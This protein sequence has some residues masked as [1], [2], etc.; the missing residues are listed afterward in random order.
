M[1]TVIENINSLFSVKSDIRQ[2][3]EDKGVDMS[4]TPFTS[5]A[6]KISEIPSGGGDLKGII[7]GTTSELIDPTITRV[8]SNLFYSTSFLKTVS[9][10]NVSYLGYSAFGKASVETV[11]LPSVKIIN[12]EC[13]KSCV[14]LVT[15]YAPMCTNVSDYAFQNCTKL[16][17]VVLSNV[18]S[19][20]TDAFTTCTA[21]S[22]ISLPKI[23]FML[24]AFHSC[25]NLESIYV[26]TEMSSVC[27][28]Y[29]SNTFDRT[30]MKDSSY[31]GYYGSI[32]VPASLADAYK[33]ATNWAYF[34]DRIVGV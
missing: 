18:S 32:Y 25:K 10:V 22:Y 20:A 23:K 4:N 34:A 19:V 15:V 17:N 6:V 5:F 21:L 28:L 7:E 8:A 9:L 3:I 1:S 33:T 30:P 12:Y 13:F 27:T 11:Y 24:G 26:G 31:L 16:S 29:Y 14:N 2:A